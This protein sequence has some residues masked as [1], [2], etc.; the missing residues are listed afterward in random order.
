[1]AEA[2]GSNPTP[3]YHPFFG[4]MMRFPMSTAPRRETSRKDPANILL[5]PDSPMRTL[6]GRLSNS[7]VTGKRNLWNTRLPV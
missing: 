3:A 1:M 2:G 6:P 5:T 7:Q 4:S